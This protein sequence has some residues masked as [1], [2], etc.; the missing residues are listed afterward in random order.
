MRC[1]VNAYLDRHC[2]TNN[3]GVFYFRSGVTSLREG[4][5]SGALLVVDCGATAVDGSI[6]ICII[7][8]EFRLQRLRK[9]PAPCL[10]HLDR[11]DKN[12]DIEGV[13]IKG[14]VTHII[15]DARSGEFDDCLVV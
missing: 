5:K 6:V 1:S 10:Q 2:N 3:P 4:I 8:G 9:H 11:T 13:E 12:Y 14:V 7:Q 15:N